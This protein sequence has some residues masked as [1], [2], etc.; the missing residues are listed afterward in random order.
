MTT[1]Y[2]VRRGFGSEGHG[3]P[4]LE[5]S[6]EAESADDAQTRLLDVLE[7][8]FGGLARGKLS[9]CGIARSEKRAAEL[10]GC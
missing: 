3:Q 1:Y 5:W 2:C 9:D 6:G 7:E 8:Q 4:I 10:A